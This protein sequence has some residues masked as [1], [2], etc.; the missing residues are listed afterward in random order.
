LW[1]GCPPPRT[2]RSRFP[3]ARGWRRLR[4]CR[5][6]RSSQVA[7]SEPQAGMRQPRHSFSD[8][9]PRTSDLERFCYSSH[10][11]CHSSLITRHCSS[12]HLSLPFQP[13]D[14]RTPLLIQEGDGALAPGGSNELQEGSA[15]NG[16][17]PGPDQQTNS[18]WEKVVR[19]VYLERVKKLNL[20]L[21][22]T[23]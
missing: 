3:F 7:T 12:R 18:P 10:V 22:S 20:D 9:G 23:V 16:Y 6:L 5:S 13:A 21:F 14:R 1:R 8:F 17:S 15:G 11:T 19:R 2:S 4:A